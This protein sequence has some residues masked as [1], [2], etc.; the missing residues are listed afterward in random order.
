MKNLT[1]YLLAIDQG[2]V[3]WAHHSIKLSDRELFKRFLPG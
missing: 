3:I 2:Y 1:R